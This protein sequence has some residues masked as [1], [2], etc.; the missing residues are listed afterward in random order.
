MTLHI[1]N[2]LSRKKEPFEPL[3]AGQRTLA[4][5][6]REGVG[7]VGAQRPRVAAE[8]ARAQQVADVGDDPVGARFDEVVVVERLDVLVDGAEDPFDEGEVGFELAGWLTFG[9][10]DS[11]DFREAFVESHHN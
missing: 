4:A 5:A 10:S 8:V 2:T 7:H 1:T 9:V 3:D 11:V 6:Q